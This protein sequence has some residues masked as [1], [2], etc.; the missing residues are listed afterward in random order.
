MRIYIYIF[1][2]QTYG[3]QIETLAIKGISGAVQENPLTV[4]L[5]SVSHSERILGFL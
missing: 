4:G 5:Y 1:F 2:L 3:M